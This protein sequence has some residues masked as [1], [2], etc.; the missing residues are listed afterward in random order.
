MN[1]DAIQEL[2]D[3]MNKLRGVM[4]SAIEACDL[5]IKQE[6]ALKGL[7]RHLTYEAQGNIEAALRKAA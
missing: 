5:T 4:F 1:P 2:R 3:S 6:N 7:T